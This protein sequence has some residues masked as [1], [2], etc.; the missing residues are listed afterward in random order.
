M[1]RSFFKV[2]FFTTQY[3]T[4]KS[5]VRARIYST[6]LPPVFRMMTNG[7]STVDL[8]SAMNSGKVVL[9]NLAKGNLATD[10]SQALGRL[11]LAQ[12]QTIAQKRSNIPENDRKPAFV[13]VDEAQNY[14]A[15]TVEVI[16]TESAKFGVHLILAHHHLKQIENTAVRETVSSNTN[17]KI[18]GVNSA[19]AWD[20]LAK[21]LQLS[22]AKDLEVL[23][24]H[25]FYVKDKLSSKPAFILKN[26]LTLLNTQNPEFYLLHEEKV[27]G[28]S[29]RSVLSKAQRNLLEWMVKKSG[30]YIPAPTYT[31]E[32]TT[33]TNTQK[34][35]DDTRDTD[36]AFTP[37]YDL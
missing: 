20:V 21:Q 18:V 24:K 9:I 34:N 12:I 7:K 15:E 13:F 2:D 5:S 14:L 8:E 23:E 29:V 30:Y 10:T 11:I 16:L 27:T 32:E 3:K 6:L 25:Q 37:K 4:T 31:P 22:S 33:N 1:V 28:D 19:E 26:P 36:D 35:A 17:V